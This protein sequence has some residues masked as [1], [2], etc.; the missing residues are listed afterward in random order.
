MPGYLFGSSVPCY[1]ET[2]QFKRMVHTRWV[3]LRPLV[4]LEP[5]DHPLVVEERSV[6]PGGGFRRSPR[7]F[8]TAI[9]IRTGDQR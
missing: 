1:P 7:R 4:K 2:L 5:T 8:C 3:G 6:S 9:V